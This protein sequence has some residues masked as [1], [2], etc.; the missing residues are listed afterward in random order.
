M[1]TWFAGNLI[2]YTAIFQIIDS[3][4]RVKGAD[5]QFLSLAI[6]GDINH[7]QSVPIQFMHFRQVLVFQV[8]IPNSHAFI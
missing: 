8:M 2:D 1:L 3:N 7:S 5:G 6:K 4:H